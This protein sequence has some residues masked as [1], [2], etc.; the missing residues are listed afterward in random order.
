MPS[1]KNPA[2][3]VNPGPGRLPDG[4]L[5]PSAYIFPGGGGG[6]SDAELQAHIDNPIDAHMA[7]AIGVNPTDS[8]G[9]PILSSVGGPVDGESVLDF[10]EAAMDL[11]PVRPDTL[12]TEQIG[13]PNSGLPSWGV[14][15]PAGIGSGEAATG[16]FT[17]GSAVIPT[18]YLLPS[19]A[20]LTA[21]AG[22]LYP[23]DRGVVALYYCTGGDF[24]SGDTTLIS[25]LSLGDVAIVGIPSALF[26]ETSRRANQ[27]NYTPSGVGVNK[28]SFTNRLPY[29]E[30]Y[31]GYGS[32]YAD[33]ASNFYRY[34]LGTLVEGSL[35]ISA[36]SSGSYLLVHWKE[37]YATSLAR[38][39]PNVLSTALIATNC[40]SAVPSTPGA[41]DTGDVATLCRHNIFQA[42]RTHSLTI[43]SI[44]STVNAASIVY[45]SGN[46][47]SIFNSI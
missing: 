7:S 43:S 30:D 5:T 16:G 39:Q 2:T 32:V 17:Q 8:N 24:A 40:Y 4:V 44:V 28:F 45:L 10:I 21:L 20:T 35:P 13:V 29:L 12:G 46:K 33:F 27:T 36:G 18:H 31:S 22:M 38:I 34:Q 19:S 11:F 26:V 15:D 47:I 3:V 37:T 42:N 25:A 23:A 6:G 14:L 1:P 41:F 9:Y